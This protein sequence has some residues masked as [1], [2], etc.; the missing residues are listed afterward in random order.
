MFFFLFAFLSK[1]IEVNLKG[2]WNDSSLKDETVIFFEKNDP[3]YLEIVKEKL[4]DIKETENNEKIKNKILKALK[5]SI[6]SKELFGLLNL[7][8]SLRFYHPLASLRNPIERKPSLPGWNVLEKESDVQFSHRLRNIHFTLLN[9]MM[10]LNT[11]EQKIKYINNA[12]SSLN[13]YTNKIGMSSYSSNHFDKTKTVKEDYCYSAVNGRI[14]KPHYFDILDGL[15]SEYRYSK[16]FNFSEALLYSPGYQEPHYYTIIDVGMQQLEGHDFKKN[17]DAWAENPN[18]DSVDYMSFLR[19]R[20]QLITVYMFLDIDSPESP[21]LLEWALEKANANAP[22]FF[23]ILLNIDANNITQKK[24]AF[25]WHQSCDTLGI[26]NACLF[27]LDGYK[28][29]NFKR[30]YKATLPSVSW[31]K[32]TKSMDS[33]KNIL[34]RIQNQLRYCINHNIKGPAVAINHE[35]IQERPLF[36]YIEKKIIEHT[37]R[38]KNMKGKIDVSK[39]DTW[40]S[41]NSIFLNFA[42]LPLAIT[43]NNYISIH[44]YPAELMYNI[45]DKLKEYYIP[46]FEMPCFVLNNTERKKFTD[47][48]LH[49]LKINSNDTYTI[50]GPL[51][52]KG[53]LTFPQ[54]SFA[55]FYANYVFMTSNLEKNLT[56]T[57]R[58]LAL[59]YR[60]SNAIDGIKRNSL[61]Y[62]ISNANISSKANSSL[63]WTVV[64]DPLTHDGRIVL[65]MM[66][67]V[68]DSGA[69]NIEFYPNIK[70]GEYGY[71][72]LF[73]YRFYSGFHYGTIKTSTSNQYNI[74]ISPYW[75]AYQERN[76]NGDSAVHNYICSTVI[77]SSFLD[78][79]G[80]RVLISNSLYTSTINEGYFS[81]PLP[82]GKFDI[83]GT[84]Q[85][86]YIVDSFVP[87]SKFYQKDDKEI[88]IPEETGRLNIALFSGNPSDEDDIKTL[89]YSI[90]NN[91]KLNLRLFIVSNYVM[92][93]MNNISTVFLS[94]YA[95]HFFAKPLIE[96]QDLT[97]WKFRLSD[98]YLPNQEKYLFLT[99]KMIFLGDAGRFT[100]L[101]MKFAIVA[102][103]VMTDNYFTKRN[104]WWNDRD[105]LMARLSRPFHTS[106]LIWVDM[107]RWTEVHTGDIFRQLF[108]S[109]MKSENKQNNIGEELFNILQLYGQFITLPE[110]IAFCNTRSTQKLAK[111]ALSL[112][113]C[114]DDTARIAGIKYERIKGIALHEY[115]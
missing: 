100:H 50:V 98:L 31:R 111:K 35:F 44:G 106:N 103:P 95:P 24:I 48:E 41:S 88:E 84:Y 61:E 80:A 93:Q 82:I 45:A 102:S 5:S 110:E 55:Q 65:D 18:Y 115:E 114:A 74:H 1:S 59:F 60:A 105:H 32:L 77:S 47:D 40:L 57:E 63:T 26:R 7:S 75:V 64:V 107:E 86:H 19:C 28:K 79:P 76:E 96:S 81:P 20:K 112:D 43:F 58:I 78:N 53:N 113:L 34:Q 9:H 70:N 85:K 46:N 72:S 109:N 68:L 67:H 2:N 21:A 27:L 87:Y 6:K 62:N 49:F 29:N 97:T 42:N 33:N 69:A 83:F 56:N 92:K 90:K 39:L 10:N 52:F 12:I 99:N 108:S 71:N 11:S 37:Y 4:K 23:K 73:D 89:L 14:L 38:I 25:A 30:A 3:K 36:H 101:P 13:E 22:L 91:T 8:L 15:L 16:L 17:Y 104:K 51:V 66:T 54:Q 94:N